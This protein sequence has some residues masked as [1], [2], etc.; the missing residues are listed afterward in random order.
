MGSVSEI[1][2][3]PY[4]THVLTCILDT[5][6]S[7]A[8]VIVREITSSRL[9]LSLTTLSS[10]PL[11]QKI[12]QQAWPD[13][14]SSSLLRTRVLNALTKQWVRFVNCEAGRI[15]FPCMMESHLLHESDNGIQEIFASFLECVCHQWGVWSI[16]YL[17]ERGSSTMKECIS[18]RLLQNIST[19]SLSTYGSKA[20]QCAQRH[21]GIP[22]QDQLAD[23]LC[24]TMTSGRHAPRVPGAS[25]SLLIDVAAAQHGLPIITQVRFSRI[26]S[27]LLTHATPSRR[28]ILITLVRRHAM[29]LKSNRSGG[30]VVQLCGTWSA[31]SHRERAR[32][33]AG[34]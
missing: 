8:P 9:A 5:V 28:T 17:I 32:V 12:F 1:S 24:R 2:L 33:Y 29:V 27:K 30:R 15:L 21:C 23:A 31:D 34:Y 22:F 3:S 6:P 7:M 11:W 10:T 14:A 26:D 19:V 20:L 18:A 25:R 13:S 16:Q 4:G